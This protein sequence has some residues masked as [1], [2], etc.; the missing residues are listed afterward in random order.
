MCELVCIED[1][2]QEL[3]IKAM[4]EHTVLIDKALPLLSIDSENFEHIYYIVPKEYTKQV[5][6]MYYTNEDAD[7]VL[8]DLLN[9]EEYDDAADFYNTHK[10]E[11]KPHYDL[12]E[13]L[14]YEIVEDCPHIPSKVVSEIL[15]CNSLVKDEKML[16]RVYETIKRIMIYHDIEIT[17]EIIENMYYYRWYDT[18]IANYIAVDT[19]RYVNEEDIY[20][21]DT[22]SKKSRDLFLFRFK[23][24]VLNY[25]LIR[26]FVDNIYNHN[27]TEEHYKEYMQL[28]NMHE[29]K[30]DVVTMINT[31][32]RLLN[33][34]N[35]YKIEK[36]ET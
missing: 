31:C 35:K 29:K 16:Q 25:S 20:G 8:S 2:N 5:I 17:S 30:S 9:I 36:I 33:F 24:S 32:R 4:Y 28:V 23:Y 18:P 27:L 13:D 26:W 15:C 10:D 22:N 3:L 21:I 1:M 34:P 11:I 7:I 14:F 6:A 12:V 19:T